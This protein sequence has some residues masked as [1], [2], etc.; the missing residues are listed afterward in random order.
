MK[1]SA[2]GQRVRIKGLT[3]EGEVIDESDTS[4]EVEWSDGMVSGI[5]KQLVERVK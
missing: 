4:Y 2:I 3:L 5:G 1:E